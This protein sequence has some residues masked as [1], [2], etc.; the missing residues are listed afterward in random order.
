MGMNINNED[1]HRLE[2]LRILAYEI[3]ERMPKEMTREVVDSML[4]NEKGLPR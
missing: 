2:R 1:A 4:Y 3:S